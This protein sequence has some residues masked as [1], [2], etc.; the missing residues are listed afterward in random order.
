VF[1]G[2]VIG[3]ITLAPSV[4]GLSGNFFLNPDTGE[5]VMMNSAA[6]LR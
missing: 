6:F 2:S 3:H 5:E 1:E 4:T